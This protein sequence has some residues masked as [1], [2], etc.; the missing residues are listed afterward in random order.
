M[1][2]QPK[3]FLSR[4]D[5]LK[6]SGLAMGTLA[7]GHSISRTTDRLRLIKKFGPA[8]RIPAFEFHGDNYYFYDGAYCMNPATFKYLMTWLQENEF[9][10]ASSDEVV[11]YIQG[12]LELPARSV[13]LT[14]DSGNV[15]QTSLGRMIPVLQ[16]TGMHFISLIWTRYM[17]ANESVSCQGDIC[18]NA[19]RE[20]RD[21]GVFSF[22]S[23]S[24]THRDFALLGKEDGLG[25]MLES[26]KE[27]EDMLGITPQLISWPFESVPSWASILADYGFAGAFAGGGSRKTM[28]E[29]VLLPNEPSPWDLPRILPPNIGTLTSGRPNGKNIQEL[30]EMFTDGFGEQQAA[31]QKQFQIENTARNLYYRKVH[32]PR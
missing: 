29:N 23:H 11:A 24:E 15:S 21:S 4:R 27:I 8:T 2:V 18:W 20:A 7:L 3:A 32:P 10:A 28:L 19:F 14:T 9:W 17:Q 31:Y 12:H 6:V 30:M 26:K 16:D 5:F 13:I 1:P 22:G 25:D